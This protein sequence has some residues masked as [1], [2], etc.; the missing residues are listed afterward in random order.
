VKERASERFTF[1][2]NRLTWVHLYVPGR[3][4]NY[5]VILCL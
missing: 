2:G 5:V 1:C 4:V 3:P